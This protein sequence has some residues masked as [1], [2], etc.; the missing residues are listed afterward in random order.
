MNAIKNAAVVAE[1]VQTMRI[2]QAALIKPRQLR[3]E[4][5]SI[6]KLKIERLCKRR[7][8]GEDP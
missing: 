1:F 4:S 6:I 5:G 8:Y 2:A 3:K 7:P